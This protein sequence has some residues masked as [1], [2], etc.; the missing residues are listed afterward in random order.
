MLRLSSTGLARSPDDGHVAHGAAEEA[1]GCGQAW[2]ASTAYFPHIPGLPDGQCCD[3]HS[4]LMIVDD[5]VV[6]I[7]SANFS[8]R[9]MGLD[10]ECDAVIEARGDERIA[11]VIRA[12]RDELLGEHLGMSAE[13]V[14]AAIAEAG[15]SVQRAIDALSQRGGVRFASTSDWMTSP[16][17]W[18]P[19]R[20]SRT[21]SNRCRS[22]R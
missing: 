8:N 19:L 17:R 13:Q 4:K 6:R 10:T 11:R 1:A 12:F 21:R 22:T 7:G 5:E 2:A 15:G 16:K 18:S 3:L 9:S 14:D 20:A